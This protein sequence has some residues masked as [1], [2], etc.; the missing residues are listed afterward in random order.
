MSKQSC[1]YY[2]TYMLYIRVIGKEGNFSNLKRRVD[3]REQF[4]VLNTFAKYRTPF[5]R[6]AI[7][8][9]MVESGL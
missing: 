8:R 5:S 1:I 9:L 7:I 6:Y 3:G 2:N 4:I